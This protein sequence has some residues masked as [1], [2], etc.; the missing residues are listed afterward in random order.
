[1]L[2]LKLIL[3][4]LFYFSDP[5]FNQGQIERKD[6]EI[7]FE[8]DAQIEVGSHYLGTEFHHSFPLPQRISFY[9]PAAN[10]IDLSTDYW[11][12]DSTFIMSVGLKEGNNIEWLGREPF[13]F[14]LTPYSV[15]F[16]KI[17]SAKH[18]NLSY[19]YC[20]SK[21]AMVLTIEIRNLSK[22]SKEYLLFT[23]LE[24]S[25]KTSHSYKLKN[26]AWTEY[27]TASKTLFTNFD[28]PETRHASVFVSNAGKEPLSYSGKSKL[29][30]I[31]GDFDFS[32]DN[33]VIPE[34][35]KNIPA[36]GFIYKKTLGPNEKL[37]VIKIIGSCRKEENKSLV[38]YLTEN[39]QQEIIDQ[40]VYVL[41]EINKNNFT[42][43]DSIID[44]SIAWAKA[45]LTVNQHY[46]DG[47]VQ[48]MPCPAEYNFYFTHDVL[49]TDLAVV[50]L[51][52]N[53]VRKD[54]SFIIGHA[55][56]NKIIP[57]AYYWKDSSYRTEYATP[58]NWNHFWFVILSASYLRHS[59]DT[60]FLEKLYPY[61]EK[62]IEQTLQNEKDGLM[63]AY[64]PDWWDIGKNYGPR[65]Y[66]TIL[67]VKALN[68]Y[69]YISETLNE[70]K[71]ALKKYKSLADR[72]KKN[73]N[74]KLWSSEKKFLMNYFGDGS[75][76]SHY[77]M[78]SL[79]AVYFDL[80]DSLK[81]RQQMT[82]AEK[83]LFDEKIGIYT[84]YPMDFH[85]LIK[86]WN[87]AGNEAGDKFKYINGGIWPHANAWFILSLL[88]TGE[89]EK[90]VKYL[91]KWMTID[92]II[93][94]PNGQ[95][96]MYEYRNSNFNNSKEYGKIDKPQFMW[97][98]GWYLY[99][100]YEIYGKPEAEK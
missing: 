67:A 70:N 60:V 83:F 6:I 94:S 27:D 69:L 57:H 85:E 12:R 87:F 22:N 2:K 34:T 92:G 20:R 72:M 45:V 62:S 95:P 38:K 64:R 25:L 42:T 80:L 84:V 11:K 97:A 56:S 19:E 73:L 8:G 61:I 82:A 66:M 77:Y 50:N 4:L 16:T 89:K 31:N 36:A 14:K 17:D 28:D 54:L 7:S 65:S 59:T 79:L 10:S 100:V 52:L 93:D 41:R 46:I 78:G 53:R 90:A 21:P 29:K 43:G 55:D 26:E 39:Y 48:P 1:M 40:E 30:S 24:T 3:I 44:K 86:F 98:A 96:A 37:K 35:E 99:C 63:W 15:N 13:Q 9:Y 47:T 75:E 58:D 5:V 76:D 91:K 68:D 32:L 18:I 74:E 33:E 23:S 71:S 49:L 51:D 81:A 88:K